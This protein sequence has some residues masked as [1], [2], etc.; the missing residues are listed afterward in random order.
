VPPL[1]KIPSYREKLNRGLAKIK[2]MRGVAAALPSARDMLATS[3]AEGRAAAA[4]RGVMDDIEAGAAVVEASETSVIDTTAA[5]PVSSWAAGTL[6]DKLSHM[7]RGLAQRDFLQGYL[8]SLEASV[9]GEAEEDDSDAEE[10]DSARGFPGLGKVG[11]MRSDDGIPQILSPMASPQA[12][13]AA[14]FGAARASVAST[15]ATAIYKA[16]L[17]AQAASIQDSIDKGDKLYLS[18]VS[19]RDEAAQRVAE[20]EEALDGKRALLKRVERQE[21]RAAAGAGLDDMAEEQV[22]DE[23]EDDMDEATDGVALPSRKAVEADIAHTE[24]ALAEARAQLA[25]A[26][27]N[28]ASVE[29]RLAKLKDQLARVKADLERYTAASVTEQRAIAAAATSKAVNYSRHQLST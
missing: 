4:I 11:S 18:R 10:A 27:E 25:K 2:S 14:G 23:D 3:R 1:K 6:P 26:Q 28:L 15:N 19:A 5:A 8:N 21:K 9:A 13:P 24:R 20:L 17:E 29:A 7:G 22:D 12:S 16:S